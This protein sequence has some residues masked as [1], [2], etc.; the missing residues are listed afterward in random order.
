[1]MNK[2]QSITRQKIEI[3]PIKKDEA[4][5]LY[6]SKRRNRLLK[7]ANE[8]STL[9]GAEICIIVFFPTGNA[10]SFVHLSV[11]VV[12]H[13]FLADALALPLLCKPF[14]AAAAIK[15]NEDYA[16]LNVLLEKENIRHAKL[17]EALT[18][19]QLGANKPF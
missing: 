15:L 6:F 10:F 1:M 16:Q 4:R 13:R 19:L 14:I 2:K 12:A 8:L 9:Y 7:K 5:K 3:K 11:D 18:A 17:D